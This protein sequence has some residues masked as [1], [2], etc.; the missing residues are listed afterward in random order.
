MSNKDYRIY[1]VYVITNNLNGKTYIGQRLCPVNKTPVT[2]K[3]MGSGVRLHWS[4]DKH[5]IEN[6]SKEIVAICHSKEIVDILEKEYIALYRSIG[7]AEYNVADGGLNLDSTSDIWK[8]NHKKTMASEKW[9]IAHRKAIDKEEYHEKLRIA[10]RKR[11]ASE[12]AR[13]E[14][15]EKSRKS[16]QNPEVRKK[17]MES[18][19][20]RVFSEET[21][22]KIGEAN[23]INRVGRNWYTNGKIDILSKECPHGFV[24]GRSNSHG[25]GVVHGK[26]SEEQKQFYRNKFTGVVWWNNGVEQ[27]RS[28]I[29]PDG[30]VRGKLPKTKTHSWYTNGKENIMAETCP[31]GFYLGRVMP[32]RNKELHWY[33]NGKENKCTETCPE[34]FWEGMIHKKNFSKN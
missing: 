11:W 34:G 26:M 12:K 8:E 33:T 1:Y 16:W 20:G 4:Y 3:Y 6:F 29:Q 22:R 9:R 19:K 30:Y 23:K 10:Q 27:I 7:K 13:K 15:G 31:E 25:K 5:G 28:K 14:C 2:D 21:R 32:K 18:S 24:R 17:H